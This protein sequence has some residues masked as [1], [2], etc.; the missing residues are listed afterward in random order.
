VSSY[1]KP[2]NAIH[3]GA[4]VKNRGW[5]LLR[6]ECMTALS[7]RTNE[8]LIII[9][10]INLSKLLLCRERADVLVVVFVGDFAHVHVVDE[11]LSALAENEAD[12]HEAE[13]RAAE[14]G[15]DGDGP[16][17]E[18]LCSVRGGLGVRCMQES[19]V[20]TVLYTKKMQNIL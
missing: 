10:V 11:P 5:K 2:R 12:A 6:M 14:H 9:Q 13:T 4:G 20:N 3:A 1:R 18:V 16:R 17:E 8:P 19:K 15:G 7:L